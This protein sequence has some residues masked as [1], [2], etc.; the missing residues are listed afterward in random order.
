MI[1]KAVILLL[2]F[3]VVIGWIGTWL[4]RRRPPRK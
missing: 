2:V 1:V 3:L 4:R